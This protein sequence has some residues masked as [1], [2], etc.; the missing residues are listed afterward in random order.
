MPLTESDEMVQDF[1]F[2]RLYKSIDPGIQI[3]R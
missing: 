2:N 1:V 3:G